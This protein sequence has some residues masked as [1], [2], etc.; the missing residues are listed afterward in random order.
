MAD[1]G[2]IILCF[3]VGNPE[4]LIVDGMQKVKCVKCQFEV[5]IAPSSLRMQ[6]KFKAKVVCDVCE[7]LRG[8]PDMAILPL[9][10]D[11]LSEIK[12]AL[13]NRKTRN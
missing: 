8:R 4:V 6:E 11:Q 10:N 2:I 9:T 7:P 12:D 5:W 1:E 13:W 3:R